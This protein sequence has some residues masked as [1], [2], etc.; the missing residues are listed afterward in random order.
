MPRNLLDSRHAPL[1]RQTTRPARYSLPAISHGTNVVWCDVVCGEAAGKHS[2]CA[3]RLELLQSIAQRRSQYRLR[4][5][6]LV[7]SERGMTVLLR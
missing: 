4:T 5:A 3:V 6:S 1:L 7:F 2:E